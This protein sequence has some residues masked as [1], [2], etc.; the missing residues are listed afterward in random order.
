MF[1][2]DVFQKKLHFV[3]VLDLAKKKTSEDNR[4]LIFFKL[5]FLIMN[6]SHNCVAF[7]TTGGPILLLIKGHRLFVSLSFAPSVLLCVLG[8]LPEYHIA[9]SCH[10]SICFSWLWQFL[11]LALLFDDLDNLLRYFVGCAS[12][13][14]CLMFF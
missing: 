9:F 5:H 11:R 2:I 10:V 3:I 8:F 13:G 1:S 14:I 6:N 7:A 12:I 4:V